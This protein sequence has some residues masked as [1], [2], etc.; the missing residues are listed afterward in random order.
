MDNE[1]KDNQETSDKNEL[2][3]KVKSVKTIKQ[4]YNQGKNK[5]SRT[6]SKIRESVNKSIHRKTEETAERIN[7]V[8]NKN[9][10]LHNLEKLLYLDKSHLVKSD[11]ETIF[12]KPTP[13]KIVI[14]ESN[15]QGEVESVSIKEDSKIDLYVVK[16]TNYT[17][18]IYPSFSDNK[19]PGEPYYMDENEI[20]Y[21]S[22]N[23]L[24]ICY[25]NNNTMAFN[26]VNL[27]DF[28]NLAEENIVTFIKRYNFIHRSFRLTKFVEE[29][30]ID[31]N[32]IIRITNKYIILQ[33][34]DANYA[35][36]LYDHIQD[37]FSKMF[38]SKLPTIELSSFDTILTLEMSKFIME[39]KYPIEQFEEHNGFIEYNR[40]IDNRRVCVFRLKI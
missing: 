12:Y 14:F 3:G 13:K 33:D 40:V 34:K 31:I 29:N 21:K 15:T 11:K 39:N 4:K 30:T 22:D 23:T 27:S 32:E 2:I 10:K 1:N 28:E 36:Y 35:I 38:L 9:S 6:S 17:P 19:I 8:L 5:I 37:N 25:K 7:D 26:I 18:F 16:Y 20:W 24:T